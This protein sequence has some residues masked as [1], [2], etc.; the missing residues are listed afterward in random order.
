MFR[1]ETSFKMQDAVKAHP[2]LRLMGKPTFCFSFTSDEFDIYHVNDSMKTRG[3]RFNGQQNPDAIIF[4]G[5]GRRTGDLFLSDQQIARSP[6]F[7]R[8]YS[9]VPLP[10]GG[11]AYY[12]NDRVGQRR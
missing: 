8:N 5:Q 3:W 9:P 4:G 2:E 7:A 12:R 6:A 11:V 10:G 1:F